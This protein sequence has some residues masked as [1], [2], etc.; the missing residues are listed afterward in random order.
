MTYS[1]KKD[2]KTQLWLIRL[3][4]I[5]TFL[6]KSKAT[7]G[8][9]KKWKR[10]V[11]TSA[12][13]REKRVS[14]T[15]MNLFVLSPEFTLLLSSLL[16]SYLQYLDLKVDLHPPILKQLW[17]ERLEADLELLERTLMSKFSQSLSQLH[18]L[19]KI[20]IYQTV[21]SSCI[22]WENSNQK[23]TQTLSQQQPVLF[24]WVS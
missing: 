9:L 20:S 6:N 19:K 14:L 16:E 3:E 15:S 11:P 23:W 18:I 7:P 17:L 1:R 2:N 13:K 24:L 5:V 22:W 21:T 12:F 10:K 8:S 4:S